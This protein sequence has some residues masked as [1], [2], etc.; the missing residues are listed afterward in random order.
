MYGSMYYYYNQCIMYGWIVYKKIE[1]IMSWA[2]IILL[3]LMNGITRK[4]KKN[5]N[6]IHEVNYNSSLRTR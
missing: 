3:R 2:E 6:L 5:K 1:Q 4:E